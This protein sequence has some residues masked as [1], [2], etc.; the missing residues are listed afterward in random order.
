MHKVEFCIMR[1][2]RT[3]VVNDEAQVGMCGI[4]DNG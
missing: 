3:D 4:F 1:P 2:L